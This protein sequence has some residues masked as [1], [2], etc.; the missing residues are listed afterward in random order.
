MPTVSKT[1][2]KVESTD[3]KKR[4]QHKGDNNNSNEHNNKHN[5]NNSTSNH[6]FSNTPHGMTP[7]PNVTQLSSHSSPGPNPTLAS[8]Q[9]AEELMNRALHR[10]QTPL[11][12]NTPAHQC[13]TPTQAQQPPLSPQ[14]Q[15][16]QQQQQQ[17]L[18]PQYNSQGTS[19]QHMT[20]GQPA[21]TPT[22]SQIMDE[23]DHEMAVEL[24]DDDAPRGTQTGPGTGTG[25]G[26]GAG[27]GAGAGAGAGAGTGA[28]GVATGASTGGEAGDGAGGGAQTGSKA[29]A[30]AGVGDR[31]G[32]GGTA[33]AGAGASGRKKR[34]GAEKEPGGQP[35]NLEQE[36][37]Q[38]SAQETTKQGTTQQSQA[39]RVNALEAKMNTV[40]DLLAEVAMTSRRHEGFLKKTFLVQD[41]HPLMVLLMHA[42]LRFQE[43]LKQSG[44]FIF[45]R[46]YLVP[47]VVN[48]VIIQAAVN[49]EIMDMF[50][51]LYPLRGKGEEVA[52][53]LRTYPTAADKVAEFMVARRAK[54]RPEVV[55][56]QWVAGSG[57]IGPPVLPVAMA[58]NVFLEV[59]EILL[60]DKLQTGPGPMLA[61][62]RQLQAH[63]KSGGKGKGRGRGKGSP[64]P[65]GDLAMAEDNNNKNTSTGKPATT[66]SKRG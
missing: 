66:I 10:L 39:T 48:F 4:S 21:K 16:P 17:A 42:K 51:E 20:A 64:N 5:H 35:P 7:S 36:Q 31:A 46:H 19:S 45:E 65:N 26:A 41:D 29:G 14:H 47:E 49:Q 50:P 24:S 40:V 56:L 44:A 34:S 54:K 1:A 27:V 12:G 11:V 38:E 28:R 6:S 55:V 30:G 18:F 59:C 23:L 52:A 3:I 15:P 2:A 43:V 13:Q 22:N 8:S 62:E 53:G 57:R 58:G 60:Q 63:R 37:E 9:T 32:A 25:A 61:R 33:R